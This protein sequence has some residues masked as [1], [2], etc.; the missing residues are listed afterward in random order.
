M[1]F[2]S[3][4]RLLSLG[5]LVYLAFATGCS[6]DNPLPLTAYEKATSVK[7]G[8]MYDKFWASEAGLTFSDEDITT[9]NDNAN[10]F[11]C[12]QCH[13][14]DGL[15]NAGSYIGR[16]PSMTRPNVSSLNLYELAQS[17]TKEELFEALKK[18]S[19]RRDIGYDLSQYDP[20]TNKEEGDK[21]PNLTQIIGD[22]ELWNLVKFL[23][24]GMFDVSQLY[25][26][27]YTG[28]Y[29]SGSASYDNIGLNGNATNG[30][31]YYTANCA[32]CH[33]ADGTSISLGGKGVGYFARDKS[34]ELQHKTKYGQLGSSMG[35][36]DPTTTLDEMRDLYKALDDPKYL[37]DF[38]TVISY[39]AQMQP[40]FDAKCVSCHGGN[41][42][43][44]ESP[45]SYDN[46]I[47]GGHV[48]TTDPPNSSLYT[49]LF[50]F[51]GSSVTDG[52]KAM[53]LA[54]IEQGAMD[55]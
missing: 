12:K 51:M 35:A 4:L 40:F 18:T 39:S 16:G 50:G 28:T 33:G 11:R 48:N 45:G 13:A 20:A 55:N 42:P 1:K 9:L 41:N 32:G 19:G 8:I 27:T 3:K 52:E 49:V 30:D 21:M 10:F 6:H 43:N 25:D 47:N 38:P 14:W 7:G 22:K 5:L 15:G 29:P 2:N 44:L 26:G 46:I 34:Y 36:A 17:K 24:E 53:V 31:A 23:K 37:D 54:W